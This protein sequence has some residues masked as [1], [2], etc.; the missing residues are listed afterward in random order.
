MAERK[1][2]IEGCLGIVVICRHHSN[3]GAEAGVT[4]SSRRLSEPPWRVLRG[5]PLGRSN[6]PALPVDSQ[7]H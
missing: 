4:D 3:N 7:S 6:F 5:A 2:L 1:Q